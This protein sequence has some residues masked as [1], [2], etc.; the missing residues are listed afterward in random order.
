MKHEIVFLGK[1]KDR[2]IQQGID[3]YCSRLQHYTG[4]E[5]NTLKDK[6]GSKGTREAIESQGLQMLKTVTRG[7]VVVALD[8]RGKQFTSE[9]F[10]QKIVAWEIA[11]V[12]RI[13]YLIGGPEG[14]S[15]AVVNSAQL[16]LSFSKMTFTHDMVRMLLVEQL[17]R[18][19]TIK[20][21]ERYHK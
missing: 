12:K 14:I 8:S 7:S 19:Y 11:S 10:S 2:F 13:S 21:G 3:E 20:H 9:Q 16:V 17:Y 18:A 1:T 15:E 4:I 6:S 5:I